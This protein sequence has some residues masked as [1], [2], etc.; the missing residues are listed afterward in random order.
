MLHHYV[1]SGNPDFDAAR[2][3]LVGAKHSMVIFTGMA[4]SAY[5]CY[6][7]VTLLNRHGIPSSVWNASE[8]LHYNLEGLPRDALLVAVS[9]SGESAETVEVVRQLRH[10]MRILG[11]TNQTD[12]FIAR[13]SD[14]VVPLHAG[15]QTAAGS[16]TITAT[17]ALLNLLA[18]AAVQPPLTKKAQEVYSLVEAIVH[19][20]SI[21]EQQV[22][23]VVD[24]MISA[25][26]A[27]VMGR[28]PS[29]ASALLTGLTFKEVT[30][31]PMEAM[32]TGEFRHGPLE[33]VNPAYRFVV[34]A[35]EGPTR[36]LSLRMV[37]DILD[38]G[39]EVLVVT[40]V[41]D[42]P[43]EERLR[44]WLT[45]RCDEYFF[46]VLSLI[47]FQLLA[48]RIAETKGI[49]PGKLTKSKYVTTEQ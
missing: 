6:P 3:W 46:P 31:M 32:S 11:V 7:A 16:K 25:P 19:F 5:S 4:S 38:F 40:N 27:V 15:P 29:L 9:Q 45:S 18:Y 10:R 41:N 14:L 30:L 13:N 35:P 48:C 1:E 22:N 23:P 49:E 34:L 43:Q 20:F 28:G 42:L 36:E 8:L 17:I 44:V 2:E 24:W 37:R 12:S 21:W 26:Y 39:G 33:I 47:P